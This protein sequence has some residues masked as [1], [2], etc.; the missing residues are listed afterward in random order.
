MR[1]IL[2]GWASNKHQ[3]ERVLKTREDF[4]NLTRDPEDRGPGIFPLQIFNLDSQYVI[5]MFSH[6]LDL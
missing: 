3:I 6:F 1:P 2:Y 5:L 4:G